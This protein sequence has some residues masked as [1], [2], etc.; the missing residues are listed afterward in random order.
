MAEPADGRVAHGVCDVS[1]QLT[2]RFRRPSCATDLRHQLV[3]ADSAH[4]AGNALA[5]RLVAEELGQSL[6]HGAH[7]SRVVEDHHR[8]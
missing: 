3:L 7:V 5:A 1:E 4:A 6:D 2:L 8:A